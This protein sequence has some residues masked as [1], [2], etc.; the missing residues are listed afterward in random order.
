MKKAGEQTET[1]DSFT[2]PKKLNG[3]PQVAAFPLTTQ[4]EISQIK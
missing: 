2:S 1:F 3:T 4:L